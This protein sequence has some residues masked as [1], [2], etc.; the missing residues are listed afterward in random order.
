MVYKFFKVDFAYVYRSKFGLIETVAFQIKLISIYKRI[1]RL[2]LHQERCSGII[3]H[4]I[5]ACKL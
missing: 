2:S 5:S 4:M 1:V 3:I